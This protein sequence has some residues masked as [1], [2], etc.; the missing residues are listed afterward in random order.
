MLKKFMKMKKQYIILA[1]GAMFMASCADEFDR[2][3]EVTRP[4]AYKD[5]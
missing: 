3:F 5:R 2:N 1:L 4:P